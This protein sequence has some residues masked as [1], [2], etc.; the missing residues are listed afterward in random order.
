MNV[1]VVGYTLETEENP[2]RQGVMFE[3]KV[4]ANSV[5]DAWLKALA[6]DPK[7]SIRSVSEEEYMGRRGPTEE[8]FGRPRKARTGGAGHE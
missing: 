8:N 6:Q 4:K 2:F 1:Y 3:T 5:A 7:R